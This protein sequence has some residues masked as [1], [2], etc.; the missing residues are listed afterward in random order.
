VENVAGVRTQTVQTQE[1]PDELEAPGTVIAVTTAQVAARTT[2]TVLQVTAHEGDRVRRGQLLAEL[3]GRELAAHRSSAQA[4]EDAASAGVVQATKTIGSAQAQADVARKT[5]DRY[6]YLRQ[7]KSVSPQE[8]D[9]VAAKNQA[10]QAGLEQA[11]AALQQAQA[12]RARAKSEVQ[13]ATA[14]ASYTRIEAP[15]DGR[16]IERRVELGSLVT[17]GVPLFVLEDTSR[18]QLE[19]TLPADALTA[20]RQGSAARVELDSSPGNLIP[21]KVG[22]ME[23]GAEP[24]SHTAKARVDILRDI[25]VESGMFGRAFFA[26]GQ[27]RA[28]LVARDALIARGQLR[29]IYTVDSSALAHWRVLTLGKSF[30]PQVEV[31]SGL[32]GGDTVVSN[33]GSLELDGKR[34]SAAANRERENGQ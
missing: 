19:V 1:V 32:G 17:P 16:V 3:D 27:R 22:E 2:G 10:A 18:Y 14:A 8:F 21:G 6:I 25:G 23:A 15:F 26:R 4:A 30:G 7:Q 31:L 11:Q 24:A 34:V 28:L 9:E 12:A 20:V 29:G 5:Y 13:A 33:P